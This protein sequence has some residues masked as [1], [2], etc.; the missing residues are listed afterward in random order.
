MLLSNMLQHFQLLRNRDLL[1]TGTPSSIEDPGDEMESLVAAE[2]ERRVFW[3]TG[4]SMGS[5][6]GSATGDEIEAREGV[7]R[8]RKRDGDAMVRFV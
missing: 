4:I 3:T 8:T 1:S 5:A 6:E 7:D 2:L